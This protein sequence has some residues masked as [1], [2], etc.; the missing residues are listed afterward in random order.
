MPSTQALTES[1]IQTFHR[2]GFVL[3]KAL[4]NP[5]EVAL[6]NGMVENNPAIREAI[7]SR[8]DASG[9]STELALWFTLGD[10]VFGAAARCERIVDSIESV[11]GGPAS[12]YHSKLTLKRPRVGGAWEWHQ[13]FGYWYKHGYLYP[14][15]ASVFIAVDA[16]TRE[17]GCLQV[18]RGSHRIGR[19]DHGTVGGQT[20][21]DMETVELA[22]RRLEHVHVEM[23][24]G[25]ALF[26]HCNT[27]HASGRNESER[28]RNIFLSCYSRADNPPA[29]TGPSISHTTITKLADEEV[30][31]YTC[32]SME[33]A[34]RDYYKPDFATR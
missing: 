18:L 22:M 8:K 12:F 34:Q 14:D 2:D 17:N 4:F 15:L 29:K 28:S 20:G 30:A 5:Q 6:M 13:D 11:L 3:R 21:A 24:P 7:Y 26:F 31:R 16:S 23:Q 32:K 19:I 33:P 1:E 9:A 10:D 25:D 27:L